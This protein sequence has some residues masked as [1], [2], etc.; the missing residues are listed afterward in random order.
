MSNDIR[1]FNKE[2]KY[3]QQMPLDQSKSYLKSYAKINP[4]GIV[5]LN[6]KV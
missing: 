5:D 1:L 2:R 4:R 3:P 6:M